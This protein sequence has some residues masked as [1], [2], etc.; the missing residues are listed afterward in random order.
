MTWVY[1]ISPVRLS[2]WQPFAHPVLAKT[3]ALDITHM[4]VYL[5]FFFFLNTCHANGNHF[6]PL[7]VVLAEDCKIVRLIFLLTCQLI[8]KRCEMVLQQFKLNIV[9]CISVSLFSPSRCHLELFFHGQLE[10][11][12]GLV[13]FLCFA[14]C[15]WSAVL[16]FPVFHRFALVLP[17]KCIYTLGTLMVNVKPSLSVFLCFRFHFQSSIWQAKAESRTSRNQF[18]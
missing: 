13:W 8:R 3:L 9:H 11:S 16:T 18:N 2:T 14:V 5:F 6:I 1:V 15:I 4:L 10:E 12:F 17:C 7:S